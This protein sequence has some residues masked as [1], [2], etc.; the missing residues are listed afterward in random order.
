MPTPLDDFHPSVRAWFERRFDAPSRAQDLGWP[1]IGAA[2]DAAGFDVLLCAPTGSGKTL[3]AFMWAINGLVLDAAHDR[4]RDEV[5]VLYVS[6]LKALANDIRLNLE[7][8]LHGVRDVGAE[9]GLDLSRIRAGLRTGDTSAS[10]RTA[11]LR[12]PPHILVTTPES[13]F[14]LLNSPK[15]REKL[16]SVRHVIVDELHALA[17]NKRG[18]HLAL[19]LERLERFVTSRGNARPNRIGLSATLNPIEKL[20]G[21]LAG[22]DVTRD[23]TR[24]PRPIKIVRADDR[25]RA[26]DLQV[27]APG[28]ELGPLA[29]HPHWEAMYD[30]VAR[31]IGEHR[32][33]L[34]FTLRRRHAQRAIDRRATPQ[35][36]RVESDRRDR[37]A[38]TWYRR[39][40]GRARMPARYAQIHLGRDSAHRA[41]G[42]QPR[43]HTEGP[44]LRAHHRRFAR[45]RGGGARDSPRASRRS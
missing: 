11:M 38:R 19:T 42:A 34:V 14:I 44:L 17:G 31:L 33:T 29:T 21:F 26:M 8:P 10:E 2:N 20:A 7:E 3:A 15:F 24:S 28:P 23:G 18:A 6:P 16:A 30:E 13:L 32:T 41:I 27:I 36:R 1:V 4:L 5:S 22:Y 9:S 37:V 12:R 45:M 39:W 35:A 40:R 43:R 25:V